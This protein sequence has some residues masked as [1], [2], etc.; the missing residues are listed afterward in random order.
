MYTVCGHNIA[1]GGG[2]GW[3]MIVRAVHTPHI[4]ESG[5]FFTLR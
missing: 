4:S 3:Y 2:S 1:V 5:H